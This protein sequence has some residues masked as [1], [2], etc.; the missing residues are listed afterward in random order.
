MSGAQDRTRDEAQARSARCPQCGGSGQ[1]T[2]YDRDYRG[3]AVEYLT[4][5]GPG[6]ELMRLPVPMRVVAHC[7]CPMG[8]WLRARTARD[9]LEVIPGLADVLEGRT[10][11]TTEDPS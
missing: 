11:W 4:R 8:V 1:V 9:L 2:V 6:G 7:L 3:H 10:R 5:E